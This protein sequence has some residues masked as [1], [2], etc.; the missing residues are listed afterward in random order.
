MIRVT[1]FSD[2]HFSTTGER[3]HGGMGYDTDEAWAAIRSHA[4]DGERPQPDLVVVTGDI[5]DHGTADEYVKAAAHLSTVPV[6]VNV[7]IGNHDFHLPFESGLPRP[8]LTMSRTLRVGSWLFLFADSNYPGKDYDALGRATDKDDRIE[9]NGGFGP[10]ESSWL[11]DTIAATDADHAFI[12]VHHP[13]AALGHFNVPE[14]DAEAEALV[15]AHPKLRG[16]GC[17]HTHT[18]TVVHLAERPVFTCPAFTIN[19][20]FRE[21]TTLPPGYRTYE[22]HDD[23][24]VTSDCHL[25]DGRW[26][27]RQ[28]P[29][30]AAKWLMGELTWDE[31]QE[32][33]RPPSVTP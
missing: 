17:G 33:L 21:F 2:T 24:T 30:P 15:A 20:D 32:R 14:Y 27:R 12:W 5:A 25:L 28:L 1:Q 18:D 11:S 31:M 7:C 22:F 4:F 16:F 10:I 23:G 26:K 19:L 29:E 6:P 9:H 3:S 8:G 13:P